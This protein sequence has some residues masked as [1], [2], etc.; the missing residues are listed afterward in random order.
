MH[1]HEFLHRYSDYQDG[2]LDDA[3]LER[4][5]RAHVRSCPDCARYA[6]RLARGLT[7]LRSLSDLEPSPR[8]QD[9][10]RDRLAA[11]DVLE[12]PVTPAPAGVMLALMLLTCAAL[13]LWLANRDPA[14]HTTPAAA[15]SVPSPV[16]IATPGPPFVTFTDLS[17][18]PFQG[19]WRTPGSGDAPLAALTVTAP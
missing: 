4:R 2:S 3:G 5:M 13:F 18:P 16:A 8:F 6:A 15:R 12:I 11:N 14:L 7:V 19:D 9:A 17:V 1:C 10:L